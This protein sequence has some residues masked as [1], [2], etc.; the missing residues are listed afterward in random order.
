MDWVPVSMRAASAGQLEARPSAPA[1][2]LRDRTARAAGRPFRRTYAS[3]KGSASSCGPRPAAPDILHPQ[4]EGGGIRRRSSGRSRRPRRSCST[5]AARGLAII[6]AGRPGRP[7]MAVASSARWSSAR[8]RKTPSPGCCCTRGRT[9]GRG[10]LP[11]SS[12]SSD[13]IRSAVWLPPRAATRRM[14]A[15][16]RASTIPPTTISTARG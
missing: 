11:P 6:M 5:R 2:R 13:S 16:K 8:R 7:S 1:R 10:R 14:Q 12:T 4:D 3:P 15:K 9:K